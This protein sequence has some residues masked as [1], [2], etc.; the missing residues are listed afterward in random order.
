LDAARRA[1]QELD[2]VVV[3]IKKTSAEYA[4]LADKPPCP[5]V[6]VNGTFISKGNLIT[7]EEL[8][9]AIQS[10]SKQEGGI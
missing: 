10:N 5:S 1:E 6:M 4:E 2:V 3:V 7:Y 8:K 9:A